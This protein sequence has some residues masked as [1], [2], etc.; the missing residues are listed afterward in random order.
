MKKILSGI[1]SYMKKAMESVLMLFVTIMAIIAYVVLGYILV[2]PYVFLAGTPLDQLPAAALFAPVIA[3]FLG[4]LASVLCH[5]HSPLLRRYAAIGLTVTIAVL[6]LP[7]L[8]NGIS[9]A[10]KAAGWETA[11]TIVFVIR[12][13]SMLIVPICVYAAAIAYARLPATH[14]LRWKKPPTSPPSSR[15]DSLRPPNGNAHETHLSRLAMTS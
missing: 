2:S 1:A 14:R 12:F 13:W 7:I 3:L 4:L 11:A 10:M 9:V 6:L 5:Q 8:F 15:N